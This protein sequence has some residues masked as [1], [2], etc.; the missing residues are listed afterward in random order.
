MATFSEL[1]G[2][3]LDI[4]LGTADRTQRFT[5]ARRKDAINRGMQEFI[6]LTGCFTREASTALS[7]ETQEYNLESLISSNTF[8]RLADQQPYI[9]TV[10][11]SV[12][13]YIEG[14][15]LQRKDISVLDRED[16][17][18]R[19][20]TSGTPTHWYMRE[21]A[22]SVFLGL[23]PKPNIVAGDTWTLFIPY[24]AKAATMTGD[25]D[26]PFATTAA[27]T[28][29]R[30]LEPYHQALVHYATAQLEKLRRNYQVVGAQMEAF[31]GYVQDYLAEH[32]IRGGDMLYLSHDYF[33]A[34]QIRPERPPDPRR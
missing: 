26:I 8:I 16:P 33:A 4:E 31:V 13:T 32:R 6:R 18:W 25:T 9:K 14:K 17:S 28:A 29:K 2:T 27:G 11:S 15:S 23:H 7:D 20:A 22:N 34:A 12:T 3:L 30:S 19:S 24:V 21:D 5:T 1:Y 10:I